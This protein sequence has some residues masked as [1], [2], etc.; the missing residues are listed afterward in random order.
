VEG[1]RRRSTFDRRRVG[2]TATALLEG[3]TGRNNGVTSRSGTRDGPATPPR[4]IRDDLGSASLRPPVGGPLAE[5]GRDTSIGRDT[6]MG[7]CR[8]CGISSGVLNVREIDVDSA[9]VIRVG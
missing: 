8:G 2:L 1:Q 4:A 3:L 6:A 5:S 7:L 9:T